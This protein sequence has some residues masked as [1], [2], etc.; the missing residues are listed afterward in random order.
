MF[1][2]A[3][4]CISPVLLATVASAQN[5]SN[6]S[7]GLVPIDD[8]GA[9]TYMGHPGGLY[10]GSVNV[11]PERH[12]VD[13]LAQATHVV[14]RDASGAPRATGKIGFLSIGMSNT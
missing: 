12:T 6:T 11:R 8:L 13:G 2:H 3:V 14:P 7:T 1:R 9:G 5:C 4:A 10:P